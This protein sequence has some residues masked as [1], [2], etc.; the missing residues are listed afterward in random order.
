MNKNKSDGSFLRFPRV[1]WT[2]NTLELFERWAYYGIFNLLALYL[3]GTTESGA[4][5]FTQVQKGLIMGIVNAILYFLPIITGAIADKLGYKKVLITAFLVLSSGYYLMGK[6]SSFPAVFITFF[7]VA[8]G[9]AMFKPIISAT[10]AKSTNEKNAS[11]GFGIFYMMVNIGG[12]LGPYMGSELREINWDLVFIMSSSAIL[13]NLVLCLLFYKEPGRDGNKKEGIGK[14]I[15]NSFS[16][17]I[18]AL[19]DFRFLLFLLILTGAWTV[20]WQYFYSLPVFID[21]WNDTSLLYRYLLE[22]TPGIAH[23]VGTANGIIN[24]EKIIT[25]D[26]F[27]IVAFQILISTIVKRFKPL[28]AMIGGMLVNTI[29]LYLSFTTQNPFIL[30]LSIFIFGIGEMSYSPKILEYIGS[31]APKDKAALYMGTQFVPIAFGN[32]IGGFISGGLYQNLA[33]KKTIFARYLLEEKGISGDMK[34]DQ[35]LSLTG[36]KAS[37]LNNILWNFSHPEKFGMILLVMG[38]ATAVILGIYNFFT[39]HNKRKGA[40]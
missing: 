21:Q 39:Q 1:F 36:M 8:I 25:L 28:S 29:G 12:L 40:E 35:Y 37:E 10:V 14:I 23:S 22:H 38:I 32:F 13:V 11:L 31:I 15:K 33:D 30:V 2:A 17:L 3:T 20:Y 5:G 4:L 19:S 18:Y 9:A 26:A 7:Y 27:F 16:N 24:A 34:F 6:V